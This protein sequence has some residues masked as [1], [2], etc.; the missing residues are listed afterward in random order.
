MLKKGVAHHN[1]VDGHA[2]A[3]HSLCD[4][5]KEMVMLLQW[6]EGGATKVGT[7]VSAAVVA[8]ARGQ[9]NAQGSARGDIK[10]QSA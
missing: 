9:R 2:F 7:M 1:K 3:V 6:E 5:T 10:Q 4:W 8:A